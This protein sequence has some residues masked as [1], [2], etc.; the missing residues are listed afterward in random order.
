MLA[1]LLQLKSEVLQ[2]M[3]E[4]L[5]NIPLLV[6]FSG[7]PTGPST[8]LLL[9]LKEGVYILSEKDVSLLFKMPHFMELDDT[10]PLFKSFLQFYRHIGASD[11]FFVISVLTK[12][13]LLGFSTGFT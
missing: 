3:E 13:L 5:L 11:G 12:P 10:I 8:S 4:L 7:D 6:R 1:S 2:W 9:Q